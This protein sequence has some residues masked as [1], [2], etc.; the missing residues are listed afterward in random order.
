M[1]HLVQG[2]KTKKDFVT[3]VKERPDNVYLDD[4]SIFNPRCGSVDE[5]LNEKPDEMLFVTNPK[6]TWFANI[7]KCQS[8]IK[9]S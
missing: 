4:P 9:V 2:F 5:L 6:R 3:A 8:G 1:T 7:K